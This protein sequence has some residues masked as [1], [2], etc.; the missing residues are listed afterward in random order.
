MDGGTL[1]YQGLL[2]VPYIDGI[3]ERIMAEAHT[4]RYFVNLGSMKMYH[5]LKELYWWRNMKRDVADIVAKCPNC[6]WDDDL[7]L[8]EFAYNNNFHASIQMAPFEALYGRR[9]RSPI[10]WFKVGEVE[11]IGPDH[12]YQAMDKVKII[13]EMLKTTPKVL[14]EHSSQRFRVQGR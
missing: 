13:K 3:R 7:P 14:F 12:V 11:L 6:R 1:W 10:G 2:C 5:D 9:C 8:I 4:S